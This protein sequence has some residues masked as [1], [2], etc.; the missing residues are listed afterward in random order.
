VHDRTEAILRAND[1]RYG[2][3]AVCLQRVRGQQIADQLLIGMRPTHSANLVRHGPGACV[4]AGVALTRA[5]G[6]IH[7]ED[8]LRDFAWQPS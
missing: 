5:F 2:L 3:G 7:G 6:R 1:I 8:G 4:S